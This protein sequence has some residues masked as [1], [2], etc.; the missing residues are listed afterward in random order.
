MSAFSWTDVS[1]LA[2]A[3]ALASCSSP[4]DVVTSM[5]RSA[6]LEFRI[7]AP[8]DRCGA[9]CETWEYESAG[10]GKIAIV[11]PR[12]PDLVLRGD[13]IA[14]IVPTEL[15]GVDP[16]DFERILWTARVELSR[17]ATVR[18]KER[19]AGLA[20]QQVILV[21]VAG[22][23]VDIIFPRLVGRLM[24]VGEFSTR[25]ALERTFGGQGAPDSRPGDGIEVFSPR[26]LADRHQRDTSLEDE[27]SALREMERIQQSAAEGQISHDEMLR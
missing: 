3:V 25:A 12:E 26:E 17:E 14:S 6:P 9:A 7:E 4:D 11:A 22:E 15:S 13:D 8:E 18:L 23:P 20:A 5:P 10:T 21:S 19:V 1:L 27:E 2:T 16:R 24:V